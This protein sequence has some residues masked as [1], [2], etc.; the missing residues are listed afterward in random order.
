VRTSNAGHCLLLVSRRRSM[1]VASRQRW[2]SETS[3]SG[4]GIRTV[5]K[6]GALQS[7]SSPA[8]PSAT[9]HSL[10]AAGWAL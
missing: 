8:D 3:F 1:R 9:R 4:W 10:I 6:R 2:H 7:M 5:A